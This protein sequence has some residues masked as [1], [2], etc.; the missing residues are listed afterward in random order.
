MAMQAGHAHKPGPGDK[1]PV[2]KPCRPFRPNQPPPSTPVSY[3]MP[4]INR[5]SVKVTTWGQ[6]T[7]WNPIQHRS[8]PASYNRDPY[9]VEMTGYNEGSRVT[10]KVQQK[11][12]KV[13]IPESCPGCAAAPPKGVKNKRK[14]ARKQRSKAWRAAVSQALNFQALESF[15]TTV[16]SHKQTQTEQRKNELPTH[17]PYRVEGRGPFGRKYATQQ[18][19]V[20]GLTTANK[21]IS[22]DVRNGRY[23]TRQYGNQ[24]DSGL[25]V[26]AYNVGA[27]TNAQNLYIT[28]AYKAGDRVQAKIVGLAAFP[29][30]SKVTVTNLRMQGAGVA[31]HT[32]TFNASRSG[33]GSIAVAGM[34]RDKLRVTVSYD[35]VNNKAAAASHS[36]DVRIPRVSGRPA[37]SARGINYYA[38]GLAD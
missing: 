24:N 9:K 26:P 13:A 1:R 23:T 19:N 11:S 31:G 29:A 22:R 14:W 32:V 15:T 4:K 30:G 20:E 35:A 12:A 37:F 21:Q 18:G 3:A 5:P 17:T 27:N 6:Q 2:V 16:A 33:S 36:F 7:T 8:Y 25:H 10:L 28:P 38:A 34:Q